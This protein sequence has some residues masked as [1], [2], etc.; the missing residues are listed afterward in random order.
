[1]LVKTKSWSRFREQTRAEAALAF[2]RRQTLDPKPIE[3][4]KLIASMEDMV[5][6]TIGPGIRLET[7]L[8]IGVW[9][10][11]C[12]P[13]QLESAILN[14]CI[15]ARDAMPG[16][17]HLTI[18]TANGWVDA[19]DAGKRDMQPGQY[20]VISVTDTGT[21]M[22]P[23]VLARAFDPFYTTKPIG[24]GTGLGLSMVYGLAKQSAG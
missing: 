2:A 15:N 20:V 4:N 9:P 22:A 10:T 12:D 19:P 18:E 23:D 11:L 16:G 6:R 17:G 3:A 1:M 8:G 13:N 5:Q 7:V 24:Q 14:L 21:G